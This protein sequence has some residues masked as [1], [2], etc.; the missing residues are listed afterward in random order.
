MLPLERK[1]GHLTKASKEMEI[2][3]NFKQIKSRKVFSFLLDNDDCR[4]SVKKNLNKLNKKIKSHGQNFS[5]SW[6]REMMTFWNRRQIFKNF[7]IEFLMKE[8]K[9]SQVS[10]IKCLLHPLPLEKCKHETTESISKW[11]CFS[12]LWANK[13]TRGSRC[14]LKQYE[15]R[16]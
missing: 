13:I 4:I 5:L 16:K 6:Y 2:S 14:R 10:E 7:S 9:Y 11:N 12:S 15:I 8:K 1:K 3:A